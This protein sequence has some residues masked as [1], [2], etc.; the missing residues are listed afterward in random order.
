VDEARKQQVKTALL[1]ARESQL[2]ELRERTK[3]T[4]L[5]AATKG[6]LEGN[7]RGAA[8]QDHQED[9]K[10]SE[11]D[12]PSSSTGAAQ[13]N[14]S[15]TGQ[16]FFKIDTKGDGKI[17]REEWESAVKKGIVR[18]PTSEQ[19]QMWKT[20]SKSWQCQPSVGTWY[21]GRHNLKLASASS[22]NA[23]ASSEGRADRDP[24]AKT[25]TGF[26]DEPSMSGVAVKDAMQAA[27]AEGEAP[28]EAKISKQSTLGV[29]DA[30]LVAGDDEASSTEVVKNVELFRET[31][32]GGG[33]L[34]SPPLNS[35]QRQ[36]KESV[37]A[38][39]FDAGV[40]PQTFD[41][42]FSSMHQLLTAP[43]AVQESNNP[44]PQPTVESRGTA[45]QVLVAS[46]EEKAK[47]ESE[48]KAKLEAEMKERLE[49]EMRAQLQAEMEMKERL[50]AEMRAQLEAEMRAKVEADMKAK[51]AAE[52]KA[53]READAR[54]KAEAAAV[55]MASV[56]VMG[57][58]MNGD[59]IPDVLQ[60]G[61]QPFAQPFT[62]MQLSASAPSLAQPTHSRFQAGVGSYGLGREG[63]SA[64][65]SFLAAPFD[66]SARD[67]KYISDEGLA[68][69]REA[70][71]ALAEHGGR[72][73]NL[74]RSERDL[75]SMLIGRTPNGRAA[76]EAN[77]AE[78]KPSFLHAP[79]EVPLASQAET[80]QGKQL[81]KTDMLM[82]DNE[83][84]RRENER[85][86]K[87]REAQLR[88]ELRYPQ[89]P[90]DDIAQRLAYQK[91]PPDDKAQRLSYQ[92]ERLRHEL[93]KLVMPKVHGSLTSE[94][95][96][97]L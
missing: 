74:S 41:Q 80:F 28:I 19:Q 24:A 96:G 58:D 23:S 21:G 7:S 84:L 1:K 51:V 65:P 92:K 69:A 16:L 71:E 46:P 14:P 66:A 95:P 2:S 8:A 53:K 86:K 79:F 22:W 60:N 70:A 81:A 63:T 72:V 45:E 29:L 47:V 15:L 25:W 11:A 67:V 76:Q 89:D 38:G 31:F 97:R 17:D 85:L 9:E 13:A 90:A 64:K 54:A 68:M 55:P 75:R 73:P 10:A 12:L 6:K 4:L 37:L 77:D 56:V 87:I 43:A 40:Q 59:G 34:A 88:P 61:Q 62:P 49:A 33:F 30:S 82:T 35:K 44:Q 42:P 26:P 39:S 27:V 36:G 57:V 50:E 91:E 18:S 3:M 78:A 20:V 83:T 48:V 52:A 93:G 32:G 94:S 5:Q